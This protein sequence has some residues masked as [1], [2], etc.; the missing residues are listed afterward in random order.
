MTTLT[1][2]GKPGDFNPAAALDRLIARGIDAGNIT[3]SYLDD[4]SAVT[5][6]I[7][8]DPDETIRAAVEAEFAHHD[9]SVQSTQQQA[10][11]EKETNRAWAKTILASVDVGTLDS[12]LAALVILVGEG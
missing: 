7:Y 6:I 3:L 8:D 11:A 2:T 1:Y 4:R 10:A 9:S 5:V 12:T